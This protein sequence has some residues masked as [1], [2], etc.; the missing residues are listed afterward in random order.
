[1]LFTLALACFLSA[2]NLTCSDVLRLGTPPV[3]LPIFH[4]TEKLITRNACAFTGVLEAAYRHAHV[5]PTIS[6]HV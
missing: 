2:D 5:V 1:M 3:P 4:T 6:E